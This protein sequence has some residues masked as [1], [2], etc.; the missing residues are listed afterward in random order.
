[1]PID[2]LVQVRQ[3]SQTDW[4]MRHAE[5][6]DDCALVLRGSDHAARRATRR[7]RARAWPPGRRRP[8][9]H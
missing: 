4:H 1:M 8:R 2:K 6:R 3:A 7:S 9:D 5:P